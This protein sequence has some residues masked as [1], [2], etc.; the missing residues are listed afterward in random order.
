MRWLPSGTRSSPASLITRSARTIAGSKRSKLTPGEIVSSRLC[1]GR[2]VFQRVA[3]HIFRHGDHPV[4]AHLAALDEAASQAPGDER[5]VQRGD[6]LDLEPAGERVRHPRRGR[7]ACLDQR[8]AGVAQAG[9]E[10]AR[11]GEPRPQRM[12]ARRAT[13]GAW[14]AAA[15]GRAPGCRP[16]RRRWPNRRPRSRLAPRQAWPARGR[17]RRG[18][19]RFA[20]A[21]ERA[22]ELGSGFVAV[23]GNMA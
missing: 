5:Q 20:E 1:Q 22:R 12:A 6:P 13:R 17:R 23:A 19:E 2:E 11:Q 8:N 16:A 7:R 9:G 21:S 18:S 10:L 3:R 14:R 4:G 15:A